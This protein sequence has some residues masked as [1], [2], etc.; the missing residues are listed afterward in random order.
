[1]IRS[2]TLFV[3]GAGASYELGLPLGE[4]LLAEIGDALSYSVDDYGRSGNA[5][6]RIYREFEWNA[7][8]SGRQLNGY[9]QAA[10]R[11]R[12]AAHLG[13]SIDNVIHQQKDDELFAWCAKLA[14]AQRIL[15]AEARSSLQVQEN[16]R[17]MMW[18][19]V[20]GTWLGGFAQLLVQDVE[21]KDIERIFDNVS[22][23]SFNYDRTIRRFL[24][25]ALSSQ[26]AIASNEAE[27][28]TSKLRIFHPYGSL[29]VLPWESPS[30]AVEFGCERCSLSPVAKNI[31]TFTEQVADNDSLAEMHAA[32]SAAQRVVFLGFGYLAQN[33]ELLSRGVEGRASQVL[34]TSYGLSEP[35]RELVRGQL[36]YLFP[37]RL[38]G[39]K[40]ARL[41]PV[42]C[43]EFIRENFR[44]LT[45]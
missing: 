34:G 23:V 42:K 44:S 3:V 38:R 6:R 16:R 25:F 7:Q 2:Q 8:E 13:L 12:D 45:S 30:D 17:R 1:M 37:E 26:F 31:L 33:M 9:L 40:E 24:P 41:S 19:A 18:P 35:D 27:I 5:D 29:G 39:Y 43:A 22:V 21:K 32:I 4:T 11:V 15:T 20:R 10:W 28:L 14:I 36:G